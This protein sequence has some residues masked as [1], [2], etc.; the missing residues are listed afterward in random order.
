MPPAVEGDLV[1]VEAAGLE[2]LDPHQRV[3][4]AG[5][6]EGRLA[7]AEDLDLAGL[8]RL[9]PDRRLGFGDVAEQRTEDETRHLDHLPRPGGQAT[10]NASANLEL[11]DQ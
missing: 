3:V 6:A 8:A 2:P 7:A 10:G 4:V 11:D 9:D 5:D 1:L